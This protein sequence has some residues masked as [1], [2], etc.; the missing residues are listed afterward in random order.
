MMP[1]AIGFIPSTPMPLADEPRQHDLA[2][3][4]VVRVH[5]VQRHLHRVEREAVR[6]GDGE[7]VQMDVRI[8]VT[9]EADVA[10]LARLARLHERRVRAVF[11]ED[12]VRV[13]VAKDL[14][15]LHEV[16]AVGLRRRSDS[17]S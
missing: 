15:M 17:S 7:H 8:L 9:G 12:A 3:A 1:L 2:E 6:R 5:H 13:V 4:A 16:D 10:Q 14:V 11:V